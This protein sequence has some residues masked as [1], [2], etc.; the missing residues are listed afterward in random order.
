[1]NIEMCYVSK[2][3]AK[4]N[5]QWWEKAIRKNYKHANFL[6]FHIRR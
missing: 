3:I 6:N 4:E 5:G 2:N 1:M